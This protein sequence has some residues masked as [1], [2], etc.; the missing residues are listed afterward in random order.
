MLEG[1][2]FLFLVVDR[3][4]RSP[5]AVVLVVEISVPEVVF[6]ECAIPSWLEERVVT[7]IG[8]FLVAGQKVLGRDT[9]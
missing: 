1:L 5:E 9:R 2:A 3:V 6:V 8:A 7:R 4:E